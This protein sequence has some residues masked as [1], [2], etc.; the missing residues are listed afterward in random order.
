MTVLNRIREVRRREGMSLRTFAQQMQTTRL[1]ALEYEHP[2]AD[3]KLSDIHRMAEVLQVPAAELVD[4]VDAGEAAR[5]RGAMIR[6][7]RSVNTL[8]SKLNPDKPAHRIA[9]FIREEIVAAMPEANCSDQLPEIG[10]RR[11]L[12][13]PSARDEQAIPIRDYLDDGMIASLTAG[14][15][16]GN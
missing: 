9:S 1:M 16:Q 4:D 14:G 2:E 10:T 6:V 15:G 3:L 7:M 13:E 12:D 5:L 8:L 11:T